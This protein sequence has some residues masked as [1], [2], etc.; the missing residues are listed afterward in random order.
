MELWSQESVLLHL[1]NGLHSEGR[2]GSHGAARRR[3]TCHFSLPGGGR[4]IIISRSYEPIILCT[5]SV[6]V[7]F[8]MCT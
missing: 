8:A 4:R 1:V 7:G 3:F 6:E 5:D 2:A